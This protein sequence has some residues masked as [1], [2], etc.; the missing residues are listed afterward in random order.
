MFREEHSRSRIG[1]QHLLGMPQRSFSKRRTA[2]HAGQL[3]LALVGV[4]A[5]DAGVNTGRVTLTLF[6]LFDDV[7]FVGKAS[8]LR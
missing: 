3:L 7:M 5:A 2:H 4:Q 8:N 6:F 1:L